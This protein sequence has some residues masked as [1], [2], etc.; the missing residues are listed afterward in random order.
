V[1]AFSPDGAHVATGASAGVVR[2]SPDGSALLA[3]AGNGIALIRDLHYFERHI[4]G[5]AADQIER[6]LAAE[7]PSS[8]GDAVRAWSEVMG[9]R[10]E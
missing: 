5:N 10:K 7:D 2:R 6:Y 3:S 9:S 8:S 1:A 4:A